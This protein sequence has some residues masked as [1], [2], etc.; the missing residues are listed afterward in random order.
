MTLLALSRHESPRDALS[1]F[2]H[3]KHLGPFGISFSPLYFEVLLMECE[4]VGLLEH[5]IA[6]LK[7]LEG[8]AGNHGTE[9]GFGTATRLAQT[10][11][12]TEIS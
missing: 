11:E 4:Q 1:L 8:R 2:V 6:L 12:M 10:N 7:G 3:A 5:E 9:I